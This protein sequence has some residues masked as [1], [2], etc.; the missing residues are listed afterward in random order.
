[1]LDPKRI[2]NRALR[3]YWEAGDGSKI[4]AQWR[5]KVW[6]VL[7]A[8]DVAA[9]PQELDIPGFG[10]HELKGNRAGTY[11]VSVSGNWRMTF[12]WSNEGPYEVELEDYYGR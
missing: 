9:A 11:A 8:L 10:F 12:R 6:R 2:T 7:N 4:N 3:R 5:R 1:M